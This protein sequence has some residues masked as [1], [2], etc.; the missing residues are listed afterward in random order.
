MGTVYLS[1]S[2]GGQPVALKVIRPEF[3]E[4]PEFRRRFRHEVGAARRVQGPFTVPV[5][6]SS[7]SRPPLWLATAHVPGPAL[8]QAVQRHG[9][10]PLDSVLHLVAGVAEALTSIHATGVIHR[11]LKPANVLLAADGPR[12]IDF[13]IA[14]AAEATSLTD[15]GARVGTPAYMAPEQATGGRVTPASDVFSLGSVACY[16]ATGGHAFGEGQVPALIYR[17]VNERPRLQEC[18]EAIREL[19]LRCLA[20]APAD[21]PSPAEVAEACRALGSGAGQRRAEGW[22]PPAVKADVRAVAAPPPAAAA[23]RKQ[24]KRQAA[25]RLA[26]AAT[27]LAAVVAAALLLLARATDDD[28]AA[29]AQ[30]GAGAGAASCLDQY[31]ARESKVFNQYRLVE[32]ATP[33]NVLSGTE[34]HQT[35]LVL[36]RD[37]R[38]VAAV[39]LYNDLATGLDIVDVIDADCSPLRWDLRLT[40]DG[41]VID[42]DLEGHDYEVKIGSTMS[43]LQQV[44]LGPAS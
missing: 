36:S 5:L 4:D 14:R 30:D 20:K 9:P 11:D 44:D 27:S 40:A 13:G 3:A 42:V 8:S 33:Q 41:A 12:V 16:A 7:T 1:H 2:R 15:T 32:G 23:R 18:P 22:L 10:L 26:V 35:A 6:D 21:R 39:R 19:I 34:E 25:L 28:E 31:L 17:I 43:L 24:E 38:A 29:R 37:A